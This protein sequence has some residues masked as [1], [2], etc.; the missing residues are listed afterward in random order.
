MSVAI[1]VMAKAPEPGRCKTRLVPPLTAD[2]AAGL[3]AAFLRDITANLFRADNGIV[4]CIA[5]APAG[6][7]A[8]FAGIAAPGTH[9]LL[10]DGSR[11]VPDG[12]TGFGRCLL[13]AIETMLETG[14]V[15]AG[16]LNADS[17]TLP[18]AYLAEAAS[19][20]ASGERRIVLGPADDGG[21]YFLGMGAPYAALFADIAWSTSGVAEQTRRQAARL[22]LAVHEL[23][24]WYDVDEPPSLDRLR[25]ELAANSGVAPHTRQFLSTLD[26]SATRHRPAA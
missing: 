2:Q 13:H 5:Y 15:A 26:A 12:V 16:V 25:H 23:P 14:H 8:A 7:E 9:L 10:A 17:P 21:Y 19:I 3:S 18:A 4:P 6:S 11:P 20:L 22:G 24:P 1:A